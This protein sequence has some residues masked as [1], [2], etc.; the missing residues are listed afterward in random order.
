MCKKINYIEE[1]AIKHFIT[2]LT[3]NNDTFLS[4]IYSIAFKNFFS[5]FR[6]ENVSISRNKNP[7]LP[8]TFEKFVME[9]SHNL[10]LHSLNSEELSKLL[11][12]ELENNKDFYSKY[13]Q[14]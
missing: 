4:K 7:C 5:E 1:E 8:Y 6:Y 2:S 12:Y 3:S 10:F 14:F 13:F 11:I 9:V